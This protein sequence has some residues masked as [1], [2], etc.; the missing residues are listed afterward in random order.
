MGFWQGY[1]LE[2]GFRFWSNLFV[3]I[4]FACTDILFGFSH[5]VLNFSYDSLPCCGL[6]ERFLKTQAWPL[7]FLWDYGCSELFWL[8][9]FHTWKHF[10]WPFVLGNSSCDVLFFFCKLLFSSCMSVSFLLFYFRFWCVHFCI[11][12]SHRLESMLSELM[13]ECIFYGCFVLLWWTPDLNVVISRC[14]LLD[15]PVSQDVL[16]QWETFPT[17]LVLCHVILP[18]VLIYDPHANIFLGSWPFF[19]PFFYQPHW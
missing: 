5:P 3:L 2:K 14:Y 4:W 6:S 19:L 10:V 7:G 15:S 11:S 18:A 8:P 17:S 16:C 9:F 1:R 13:I 12:S